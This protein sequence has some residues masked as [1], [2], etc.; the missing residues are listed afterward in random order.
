MPT[1]TCLYFLNCCSRAP[2]TDKKR[3][4]S[5]TSSAKSSDA[6]SGVENERSLFGSQP[7][8]LEPVTVKSLASRHM[9]SVLLANAQVFTIATKTEDGGSSLQ[10]TNTTGRD[11][12]TKYSNDAV[13]RAT[14]LNQVAGVEEE[15]GQRIGPVVNGSIRRRTRLTF[16]LHADQFFLEMM[17]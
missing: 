13:R 3:E 7:E 1:L 16:E 9:G 8:V 12:F 5:S 2:A 14:L 6:N 15:E 10:A 11:A 4:T 17:Q